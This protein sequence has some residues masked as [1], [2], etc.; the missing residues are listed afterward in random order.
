[1]SDTIFFSTMPSP[2]GPLTLVADADDDL[3]GLY[4]DRDPIG[5]LR[6]GQGARDDR[7][8]QP[9]AQQL[10]EYFAGRRTRFDLPLAP[11]GTPFQK[12]VWAALVAIPFGQTASYRDVA[13]AIGQPAAVRAI[14]GANHRNPLAI[15]V[16][17]HRVIGADGSL[18]GYGGGLDRTR[19]LL[20]LE[21]GVA[22]ATPAIFPARRRQQLSLAKVLNR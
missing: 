10:D 3:I 15:V 2:V 9:A 20:A 1:M 6:R 22:A 18:T 8:L 21:A 12:A 16:P 7:R 14:G 5:A 4:F 13:G 11:R 17:C 19:L